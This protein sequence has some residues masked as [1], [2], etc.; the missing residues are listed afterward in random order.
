MMKGLWWVFVSTV[1]VLSGCATSPAPIGADLASAAGGSVEA[2]I[3]V[4]AAP[5]RTGRINLVTVS[6]GNKYIQCRLMTDRAIRCEAAGTL[7]QL[8]LERVLT[9]DRLG[10][11]TARG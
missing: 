6:D 1:A 3:D 10:Q 9:P 7:M 2:A 8:S 5:D 11:L 4:I